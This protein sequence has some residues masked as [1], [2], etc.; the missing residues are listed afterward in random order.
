MRSKFLR[1]LP[2]AF[3]CLL[4]CSPALFAQ[5]APQQPSSPAAPASR[6]IPAGPATPVQPQ[7]LSPIAD[8]AA[9]V[10]SQFGPSFKLDPKFVPLFGD[11]DGDG[12][13]DA[14]FF[15]TSPTPMLA[16][17]QFQF[18]I[19]DPYDAYFGTGDV[20]ITSKFDLHFDGS[21]RDVLIVFGWRLPPP[22]HKSKHISKFVII[23]TPMQTA[24]LTN[25]HV[26]KRNQS[27]IEVVDHT[28][29]HSVLYWD[30]KRWDWN[31]Q[32]M[33]IDEIQATGATE[34]K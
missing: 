23:N 13:E 9:Y 2:T 12:N 17:E 3:C 27:A 5:S 11:L 8:P 14:V 19:E 28:H 21:A 20:S 26:K 25:L 24:S 32:G 4:L 7:A 6:E 30:G 33:D 15:A 22:A 31:A 18:K 1:L 10:V 29:L 34:D 16:R